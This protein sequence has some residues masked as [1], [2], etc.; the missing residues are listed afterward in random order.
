MT[1]FVAKLLTGRLIGIFSTRENARLAAKEYLVAD[2]RSNKIPESE[3]LCEHA[4]G[5]DL[6]S[7]KSFV[8]QILEW[9][10]DKALIGGDWKVI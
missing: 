5:E 3:I 4:Q 1:V 2:C 8:I 9:T 6:Y 7:T 10:V